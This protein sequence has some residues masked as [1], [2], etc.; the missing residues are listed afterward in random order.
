MSDQ[1][2]MFDLMTSEA[3]PNVTS[4]LEAVSGALPPA[5]Q[6]GQTTVRS[7]PARAHVSRLASREKAEAPTIQGTCGPTSFASSESVVLPSLSVSKSLRLRGSDASSRKTCSKCYVEKDLND[8]SKDNSAADGRYSKCRA[9]RSEEDSVRNS[10]AAAKARTKARK[11][12]YWKRERTKGL[13]SQ[14]RRRAANKGLAFDLDQFEDALDIRMK[15][16]LCEMTGMPFNLDG[17]RTWDSPSIDRIN[18]GEGYTITNC[19][20][21]LLALNV[22]MSDWGEQRVVEIVEAFKAKEDAEQNGPMAQF[23][24]RLKERLARLGSTE[25]SLTWTKSVTP[26]GRSISRLAPSMRRTSDSGSIGWPTPQVADINHSRGTY[27][28]A[29]RTM[30]RPQ[31]PS[32]LALRAL[33]W[34]TPKASDGEGGRT[35]KTEGGG[36]AHLPIQARESAS[37]PTP[38]SRDGKDGSYTPNVPLNGLLGRMVWS[39]PRASDGEKGSPQQSFGAGGTPLPAQAFGTTQNS[40]S[41]QT[42]KRGALNPEFVFWLMGFPAEWVS[43][44]LAAMASFRKSRPKSSPR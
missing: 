1:L 33:L 36:N 24:A 39:T 42:E 25:F 7:G 40:A 3:S 15:R 13:I 14:A 18:P 17:G 26:V 43:C 34:A 21:V 6:D 32:S 28:Y 9:C 4:S 2:S 16:G 19:R 37:W 20:L 27:E 10:T 41:A 29:V 23:E 44:A 38:T 31:P 5:S 35:T 22:M 11:Q 30:N 8:F 12:D